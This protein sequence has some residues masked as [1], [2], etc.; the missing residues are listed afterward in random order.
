MKIAVISD[1][2]V[3]AEARSR[4]L[5]PESDHEWDGLCDEKYRARFMSFVKDENIAADYLIIAGDVTNRAKND[6]FK[7]ASDFIIE[8]AKA[9][10]VSDDRIVLVPGNHDMDWSS[11]PPFRTEGSPNRHRYA[12]FLDE[13]HRFKSIMDSGRGSLLESPY[14]SIWNF[15]E[16][17]IVGYNSAHHDKPNKPVAEG[18][19]PEIHHGLIDRD[20]INILRAE[21]SEIE[22]F[23][24]KIKL[25]LVHHHVVQ[26]SHPDVTLDPSIMVNAEDL[27]RFLC[28]FEFDLLVHGHKHMP[29]FTTETH[30][31]SAEVAILCAGSFSAKVH[32]NWTGFVGNQ[33][34]LIDIVERDAEENLVLGQVYSWAFDCAKGWMP[35][36]EKNW[37]ISPVESFGS[38]IRPTKLLEVIRPIIQNKLIENDG[39]V[40]WKEVTQANGRLKF[41]R[42]STALKVIDDLAKELQLT[43]YQRDA[44][45]LNRVTLIKQSHE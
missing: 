21:L 4:D 19:H 31:G 26:Y 40:S 18:E 2:H 8:A 6:E 32:T 42:K 7:I 5:C 10:S 33:F 24:S 11:M 20:H 23:S 12:A 36:S 41:L 44:D 1:F 3:G 16:L 39:F 30:D 15:K 45:M 35:S 28:E 27:K 43:V 13:Q 38:Y 37:G 25:F 9:F 29:R 17:I 14:F 22:G 34:H